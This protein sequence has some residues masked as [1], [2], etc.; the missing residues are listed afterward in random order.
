MSDF[1]NMSD[2]GKK[3]GN[4]TADLL[5][6]SDFINRSVGMANSY[7]DIMFIVQA[8]GREPISLL[9]KDYLYIFDHVRRNYNMGTNV[10]NQYHNDC[11]KFTFYKE[12][13][14]VRFANP[15]DDPMNLLDRWVPE[16][17]FESTSQRNILLSYAE[18]QDDETNNKEIGTKYDIDSA[19]PGV[20]FGGISSFANVLPTCDILKKTNDNFNYGKYKTLIARFHT[21]SMDS[22][23]KNDITQTA[24]SDQY[25]MSHGRNLLKI[26]K[27]EENGYDNPYCRAWTYHHQYNQLSRAIRP[28]GDV[29]SQ[30]TLESMERVGDYSTVGFRTVESK[31]FGFK[32]G[33]S[34]LDKYGVLN[35]KNGLVN[36]APTAKIKNY[37][38]GKTDKEVTIK[39]CMFSIEN[40]A[41]KSENIKMDEYD[42]Y[43]LSAEQKGPFG[44]RIMWFPPYDLTFSEDVRVTWNSNQFI[45]RGEKV[46]TY[47]DTERT[48]NLSFTLLIDHP[49][50]LDYWTGH[51]RN[52]MKNQ[53][54]TLVPGNGGGVDEKNNQE[55]TLLRFFAGCEILTAQPQEFRH[56][57]IAPEVTNDP[58]A[59]PVPDPPESEVHKPPTHKAIH[60]VLYYPNNYSGVDDT[61]TKSNGTVNAIYYL[62]NG[63]GAQKFVNDKKDAEDIPTTIDSQVSI[64]G[65][66]S[67]GGYEVG[68][69]SFAMGGISAAI[70]NLN[71]DYNQIKSTYADLET[72]D[73]KAQYL[74]GPAGVPAGGTGYVA[75]YGSKTYTL[76]K[77]VGSQAMSLK[78]AQTMS[79]L[80]GATH[81]WYRRRWYYRVDK[82]YENTQLS[83]P[84]SYVDTSDFGL[85][86]KKGYKSV[87]EDEAIA[88][89]FGLDVTDENTTLISF[90]DMFVALEGE[91]AEDLMS[92]LFDEKNVKI[93]KELIEDKER[94]KITEI[95]FEGHASYQGYAASNDT[96]SNNRALTFKKWMQNNKFPEIDKA[97]SRTK[98]ESPKNNVDKGDN[99]DKTV[100]MWRSASVII[101]YDESE[102]EDASLANSST[103]EDGKKDEKTGQPLNKVDK[104]EIQNGVSS[105]KKYLTTRDWLLNSED[106]KKIMA[107]YGQSKVVIGP[108]GHPMPQKPIDPW[109]FTM[110]DAA[111]LTG[112]N[113]TNPKSWDFDNSWLQN[114]KPGQTTAVTKGIV[115]R[116]DNEGEFFELLEKNDPFMHHL[117]TDKIRYFDPAFHSISPEGFNARLT[118][119]HQCTRQGSTVGGADN[120][121]GNTAYNLAFGRPPVCVLR[122]GDFYYTKIIINSI[123]IQYET[124]QWD[125]NPEGIGVMPMFAKVSLNFVFL[126][127][128][129]LAGPISRLQNAVSFNYYAN[130][131]VYDNRAE[132][133]QYDPDG[134]GREVK[135]KPFSY[136]DMVHNNGMPKKVSGSIEITK[137]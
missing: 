86:A 68:R 130:T 22:R 121:M 119:L 3:L 46:Y 36:I 11:P 83:R 5:S 34:R 107:E 28:F 14:T 69:G 98:K 64:Q 137:P 135:F 115:E 88:K 31:E 66:G 122:L 54:V 8:L 81:Q 1:W 113:Y 6:N 77:I 78:G 12:K 93:V 60:C 120:Q 100:K 103:V 62:M 29:N 92:G 55:N 80:T 75:N 95:K 84:D 114:D 131:S 56:R 16:A 134:N 13:P 110:Q 76:A 39:K 73:R 9:G 127:G 58:P 128:S 32:G 2:F 10:M 79:N 48:G 72:K 90:A 125:L 91:K 33:S 108:N 136:P 27:T 50:V 94:F 20:N 118:F 17:T 57:E 41:W 59:P 65:F 42:Q 116:Y 104:V 109:T 63:I 71:A 45:G 129:D 51:K 25:G 26:N 7:E 53:G 67:L 117:I 112:K 21:K 24:I 35:Y 99:S 52:G 18:S 30:E 23:D 15:Y 133:V 96:L 123:S 74:T 38:E 87:K 132:M 47:T 37:F 126:G 61:P 70:A 82:V 105:D 97:T 44:G 124:P 102:I 4:A 85:N 106:G 40:L 89:A 101:E 49:S 111:R 19:N 43:G